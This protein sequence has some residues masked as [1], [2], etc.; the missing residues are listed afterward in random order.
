MPK[1]STHSKRYTDFKKIIKFCEYCQ[2]KLILHNTRDIKRKRFCSKSCLY[3][4]NKENGIM[5]N[6]WTL[7]EVVKRMKPNLRKPHKMSID[8]LRRLK[9]ARKKRRK[10]WRWY[11]E[12]GTT[13]RFHQS[14]D[15]K[16]KVKE[17][18]KRDN[19]TCQECKKTIN[20]L[21]KIGLRLN[22]HHIVSIAK[23][24]RSFDNDNLVTLC[25]ECHWKKHPNVR[26]FKKQLIQLQGESCA[27]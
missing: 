4:Y 6:P 22:C 3:K 19:Y 10:P 20:E 8:G 13:M 2:R 11:V 1:H 15:W 24:G 27:C 12:N 9:E 25:E 14:Q 21:R 5:V 26:L 17:I 23:K 16:D 7:P 18:Y